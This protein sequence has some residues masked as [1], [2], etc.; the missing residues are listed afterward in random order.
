MTIIEKDL[1]EECILLPP[2]K[3]TCPYCGIDHNPLSP[4]NQESMYYQYRFKNEHGRWPTW[5]DACA[6]CP[7]EYKDCVRDVCE[8]RG[9]EFGEPETPISEF[10]EKD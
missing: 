6:H 2:S 10:W 7:E 4:H 9:A 3:G 8:K 1:L 5:A